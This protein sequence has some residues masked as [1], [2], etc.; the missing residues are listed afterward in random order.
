[1]AEIGFTSLEASSPNHGAVRNR[2]LKQAGPA[3]ALVVILPGLNYTCDNPLLYY[4]SHLA[5]DRSADVLQ[6][7]ADYA[8]PSFQSISNAKQAEW[9]LE[10]AWALIQAGRKSRRY[11]K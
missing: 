10:N 7:W 1:M 2:W 5:A 6:L 9:L 3:Q 11:G 4:L 8:L